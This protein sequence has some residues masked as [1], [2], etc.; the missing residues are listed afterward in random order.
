MVERQ[1]DSNSH[2]G[3]IESGVNQDGNSALQRTVDTFN[4]TSSERRVNSSTDSLTN[5]SQSAL[6]HVTY[7]R[8][9]QE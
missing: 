5:T 1:I 7:K 6:I 8:L 9:S 2:N 3:L 4:G